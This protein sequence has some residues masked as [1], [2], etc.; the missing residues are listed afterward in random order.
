M[1]YENGYTKALLDVVNW[2]KNHSETLK[3]YKLYKREY[4]EK[5]LDALLENRVELRETGDVTFIW[6]KE[7]RVFLNVK[8]RRD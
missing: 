7:K 8:D 5:L 2:F 1:T 6:N 3:F 4:I